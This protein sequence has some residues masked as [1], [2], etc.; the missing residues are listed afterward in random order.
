M[1]RS[2]KRVK[3]LAGSPSDRKHSNFS[4][5]SAQRVVTQYWKAG[6][7]IWTLQGAGVLT[8]TAA[9]IS[10]IQ[11]LIA[12]HGK[13]VILPFEV[14]SDQNT[15]SDLGAS[16]SASLSI[17]LN[18]YRSLFPS[19]NPSRERQTVTSKNY[20][21]L[22]QSF[23]SDLPFVEIPRSSPLNKGATV[24]E[25]IKIGPISIPVSQVVF[26]NL[27][28]FHDDTLRG[29]LE[30]WGNELVARISL[31]NDDAT[32]T[33]SVSKDQGYRALIN[34]ITVELLQKKK[35]ISPISM[36]LSA[37]TLFSEG[38]RDYLNFDMYAEDRFI[39]SAREKYN[40][41]LQADGNAD[42]ARL[43]LGATQYIS[44][45]P[46]VVAKAIEN[47]SLLIAN[48]RFNRAARIGYVASSLRYI[49]RSGGCNGAYRFLGPTLQQVKS[50]EQDGKPPTEIEELLLWSATLQLTAGYLLPGK[51]CAQRIQSIL[52]EGNIEELFKKARKGFEQAQVK[53]EKPEQYSE[54]VITRYRFYILLNT[55]YL[56]DDM[57]D[58]SLLIKKPNVEF[59][60]AALELGKEIETQKDKLPEEQRRFFATSIAG[61]VA[62]S[63]LRVAKIRESEAPD[64]G[65]LV[66]AAI[67]QLRV[68]VGS[69]EPLT[70]QW[71][72]FRLADLELARSN[73]EASL[74]WLT[75][76]YN[77]QSSFLGVFDE[78]YVPFGILIEKPE[79]RCEAINL[80]KTGSE[81]GSIAS[82]LLLVDALRRLGDL[83][84]ASAAADSLRVSVDSS[85]KWM[86]NAI[87][88]KLSLIEAKLKPQNRDSL[89]LETLWVQLGSLGAGNEFL[90]FDIYELAEIA[91]DEL[92]LTRLKSEVS[93]PPLHQPEVVQSRC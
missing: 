14:R 24:L 13:L 61:S 83:R 81:A 38:L 89:D 8:A 84:G 11:I 45:D 4:A 82:K 91:G 39:S 92:L 86:G 32:T 20:P 12:V 26:E 52:Q 51:P 76:A 57:V 54:S 19:S 70:A 40:A 90:K 27:A 60:N 3:E 78:S 33:V 68:A 15:P 59:A 22:I 10:I 41:A 36:K 79:L 50:W 37:L 88:Q 9:V 49:E 64:V 31:G 69:T 65:E 35:W 30:I 73:G 47:F 29:T 25:A 55:K 2:S 21:D 42:I 6:R 46:A 18:E 7:K 28:F 1:P 87:R 93:F 5:Q 48:P 72:L 66:S 43:H 63:Y 17:A 44:T 80:L 16:L 71:A 75:R 62:D 53:I 77:T 34:R 74:E 56:L 58:Y 67:D 85:T 23:M